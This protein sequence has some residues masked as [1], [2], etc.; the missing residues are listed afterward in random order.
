MAFKL[1]KYLPFLKPALKLLGPK[2]KYYAY[3]G[4]Q[5]ETG[6]IAEPDH[7]LIN[8]CYFELLGAIYKRKNQF[9]D[10]VILSKACSSE[11]KGWYLYDNGGG[12]EL[13]I[14]NTWEGVGGSNL[15]DLATSLVANSYYDASTRFV[16]NN[17]TDYVD[18][19]CRIENE[20]DPATT[21]A[22]TAHEYK[23]DPSDVVYNLHQILDSAKLSL[24]D[25]RNVEDV[26]SSQLYRYQV[27]C[28]LN[29]IGTTDIYVYFDGSPGMGGAY[30]LY[31]IAEKLV[32]SGKYDYS[33]LTGYNISL[34]AKLNYFSIQLINKV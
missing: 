24:L 30:T 13:L 4:S 33:T 21:P 2:P 14:M 3:C 28:D 29:P 18:Y 27:S 1:S 25:L 17:T 31:D 22:A 10:A 12:S 7:K 23:V 8:N 16:A 11:C 5:Y 26:P 32:E 9:S 34:V 6:F 19:V 20:V 15:L